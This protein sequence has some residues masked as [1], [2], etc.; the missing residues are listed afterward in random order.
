MEKH[1]F[2]KGISHHS[3]EEKNKNEGEFGKRNLHKVSKKKK[4]VVEG[5]KKGR[6]E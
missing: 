6:K 2:V 4:K 3:R 5:K 1:I